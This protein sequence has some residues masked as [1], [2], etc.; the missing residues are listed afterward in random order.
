LEQ[1][2]V[3]VAGSQEGAAESMEFLRRTADDLGF[4]I[5]DLGKGYKQLAAATKGTELSG[6]ATN[7]IFR[8]I[9]ESS[10]ALG[11][12]VADTE[13]TIRALS[14][15][16]SKGTVNFSRLIQK[17]IMKTILIAGNSCKA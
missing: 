6:E 14:Q 17:W 15:M 13:G 9:T 11:L 4:T 16:V 2:L 3:A 5:L 1:S 10:R 8:T 12:S 7:A